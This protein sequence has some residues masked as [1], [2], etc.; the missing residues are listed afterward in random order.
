MLSVN[1]GATTVAYTVIWYTKTAV[2]GRTPFPDEK[3]AKGHA[4]AMYR[5]MR[6]NEGVVS[7]EVRKENGM[8]VYSHAGDN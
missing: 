6:L 8:V 2:L 3:V 7:V 1:R 5:A 4:V